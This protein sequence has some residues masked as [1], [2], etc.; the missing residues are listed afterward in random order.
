MYQRKLMEQQL[1]AS[2]VRLGDSCSIFPFQGRKKAFTL[3][4]KKID[5]ISSH[6]RPD[7]LSL[8]YI[9]LPKSETEQFH[10]RLEIE[11]PAQ[12]E[13]RFILKTLKGR[14]FW[15]NGLAAKEAYIE[16]QDRLFID[17]NKINFAPFDLKEL[18]NRQSEHPVLM[19]QNLIDSELKILITGE[20]GTGKSHLAQKIHQKSERKGEFVAI[21][22]SSF[23]PQL[24][25][26]EL[27]GH[28]K[29]AFTGAITDKRGAFSA[30]ENG[31]L[32]LDEID[33]LPLDLQTKLLTFIDN[34]KF[35]RVGDTREESIR[36][37]LIF[38]SGRSLQVMVDQGLFRK[39]LFF[40]LKSGH[41]VELKSLRNDVQR[42]KD[43]C[44]HF[45]IEH[46]VAL[47][48]NLIEF[49]QTLAWPGNLRQLF[50][51][52]EKKKVLSRSF[53]LDFDHFDEELMLQSSDLMSLDPTREILPI[54]DLKA[55]Y[56]KRALGLC[57]G[58]VAMAARKLQVNQK[59]VRAMVL[60]D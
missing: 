29:G 56:I 7:D 16:R 28:K 40:R 34:K 60:K 42:I 58:N 22:L 10:Y 54:E 48:Q 4:S 27:F 1:Y 35:R 25:E 33:S 8:S 31:T 53:K 5:L 17:D 11:N 30:A 9:E 36:T 41:S 24:I 32:F 6:Y 2:G 52:L 38:A 21:N 19:E 44:Q 3:K 59:T 46:G 39:D 45:A 12:Y 55:N 15:L 43:S 20:T 47:T 18:T 14:A 57:E 51:H 13:G 26:S 49:Y 50:G 37:R 23:N